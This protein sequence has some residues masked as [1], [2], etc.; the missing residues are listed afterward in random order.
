V[1]KIVA[2]NLT[3]AIT[4]KEIIDKIIPA[5]EHIQT[6]KGLRVRTCCSP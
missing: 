3:D 2:A 1:I 4:E 5:Y 6:E